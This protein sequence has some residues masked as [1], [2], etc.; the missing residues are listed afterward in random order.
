MKKT[1]LKRLMCV[2]IAAIM[3]CSAFVTTA[4]AA[5]K[6]N[7]GH[8]PVI[9]IS[10]FGATTLAQKQEDGSLKAVFPP[11]ISDILSLVGENAGGLIGGIA[12][13]IGLYEQGNIEP[14]LRDI[15]TSILEPVTM[16]P[17][18]TSCYDIVPIVSGAENTSLEAFTK[19][20]Q[21]KYIP[22]TG[23]E[24]LDMEIIGDEIGDDHV[25]NF[26]FDWRLSHAEAAAQLRE[27]IK[28]VLALTGHDK[29]SVYSIS[30]GGLV[31]GQ[32]MY[33]YP[34]DNY[35]NR[36]IFDTPL[37]EG[38]DLITDL[39]STDALAL[40]L[41]TALEIVGNI[42]H[43]EMDLSF[44]MDILP[45]DGVN[46]VADYALESMI[47]P[48]VINVPAFWEMCSPETYESLKAIYLDEEKNAELIK[49]V[50]NVKNGFMSHISETLRAQ[51][52]KGV[53]V[54]I[55]ACSGV[56]LAS[57]TIENSDGIV[58]LKYSCG[59]TCA[60]FGKTFSDS[61]T[62]AVDTG[63]NNISPDRTIDLSTGYLPERTWIVNRHY[64]GQAEWDPRTYDLLMEL[65]LT[66]NIKDAYSHIEYPQFMESMAPTSDVVVLFKC[67][68]S[69][70][71]PTL[72]KYAFKGNSLIVKNLSNSDSISISNITVANESIKLTA[73]YPFVL[74]PGESVEIGFTGKVPTSDV[75]DSIDVTYRRVSVTAA[76]KTRSFGIT[77]TD[78]YSGKAKLDLTPSIVITTVQTFKYIQKIYEAISAIISMI[79]GAL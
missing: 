11:D 54:S 10:G 59:A 50:E 31:L 69:S 37:L 70:F 78:N 28:E 4:A 67:T 60:P 55:K 18:G 76:E 62:Q 40:N 73:A 16:N 65:L 49:T 2:A 71:L 51:Q 38:S 26:L 58:N 9:L 30:Q 3:L 74:E 33:D 44:I 63:K 52:D 35:I 25:F 47:L 53:A 72:S 15:I 12:N 43:T 45:I 56:P 79:S 46:S 61:Y 36:A 75:Y 8:T 21:L 17:D 1:V 64:H 6:C 41:A 23:S 39:Y 5:T 32:Y 14:P 57:G 29:V 27:Y 68:N 13:L 34:D 77:I 7:C 66:D 22:Y 48:Q 24:F 19:N 42:F 20:D